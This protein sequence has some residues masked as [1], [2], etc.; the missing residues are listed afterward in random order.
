MAYNPPSLSNETKISTGRTY[1][2]EEFFAFEPGLKVVVRT[3][4]GDDGIGVTDWWDDTLIKTFKFNTG[5]TVSG[6]KVS[7][8][9]D[10]LGLD[11]YGTP[12]DSADSLLSS[13]EFVI[14]AD[15]FDANSI[16]NPDQ[17]FLVSTGAPGADQVFTVLALAEP[18][19]QTFAV[20]VGPE[21]PDQIFDV[22]AIMRHEVVAAEP[23]FIVTVFAEPADQIFDVL[24]GAET[25][26]Q[27]FTVT[28]EAGP[29]DVTYEVKVIT[30]FEVTADVKEPDQ[31][32]IVTTGPTPPETPDQIF[33]V[34]V[35]GPDAPPLPPA[36]LIYE[37]TLGPSVPSRIYTVLTVD[38][39][40]NVSVAPEPFIVTVG[41]DNP[42]AIF[43]VSVSAPPSFQ[44]FTVTTGPVPADQTFDIEVVRFFDVK[45]YDNPINYSVTAPSN[46]AYRFYGGGLVFEDNPSL[47]ATVG[48]LIR[49]NVNALTHPFWI[50]STQTTGGCASAT[51]PSWAMQLDNNG[52]DYGQ[53]RVRFAQAGTYYYNCGVHGAMSGTITVT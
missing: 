18:P 25:P 5:I 45:V 34:S 47:T 13:T 53:V 24:V 48:Q 29:A 40:F 20:A 31:I 4:N 52:E 16:P 8:Q 42:N 50:C 32:Y 26:D 27:I 36:D 15:L 19:D 51:L 9:A 37:V 38:D 28:R 17:T 30:T 33:D 43:T 2:V 14:N 10:I 35:G 46:A 39:L 22:R 44:T 6:E 41:P 49:F 3:G 12:L 23:P 21:T 7:G 1:D 11:I